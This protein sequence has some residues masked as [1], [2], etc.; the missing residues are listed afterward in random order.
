M[1]KC[2]NH[3]YR[4]K[5]HVS[6]VRYSPALCWWMTWNHCTLVLLTQLIGSHGCSII[7]TFSG[8]S[9]VVANP[10][11]SSSS[12]IFHQIT[13]AATCASSQGFCSTSHQDVTSRISKLPKSPRQTS[14]RPAR[15][16]LSTPMGRRRVCNQSAILLQDHH[17]TCTMHALPPRRSSKRRRALCNSM[18]D[19]RTITAKAAT[20]IGGL[21]FCSF[22]SSNTRLNWTSCFRG[23]LV[24]WLAF[25][26]RRHHVRDHSG[27][28]YRSFLW[29]RSAGCGRQFPEVF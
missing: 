21:G 9:S 11:M 24:Q 7:R 28:V 29:G 17:G 12:G 27:R 13:Q 25:W 20:L 26:L 23:R 10:M 8:F 22:A 14:V 2:I 5:V 19:F 6:G 15:I 3:C 1:Y 18:T 16:V 4:V